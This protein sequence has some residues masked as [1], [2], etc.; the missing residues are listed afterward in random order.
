V[1]A[2]ARPANLFSGATPDPVAN[3]TKLNNYLTA[4]RLAA[5]TGTGGYLTP[6]PDG[7]AFAFP[8]GGEWAD[9]DV[10]LKAV[11]SNV[12]GVDV[13]LSAL[14]AWNKNLA[15]DAGAELS[16][17]AAPFSLNGGTLSGT[18][19]FSGA[20]LTIA[21]GATLAPGFG[22]GT[23]NGDDLTLNGGGT[24]Q[25]ELSTIDNTSDLLNLSGVFDK[26]S[27]GA[28]LFDFESGGLDGQTYTLVG[29]T[30]TS[31]AASDFS[32]TDLGAGLAGTFVVNPTDLQLVVT[33][34]PE[35]ASIVS[36]LGGLVSL[37]GFRRLRRAA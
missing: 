16:T 32:Y 11:N 19:T 36:L 33:V 27:A 35:P 2:L 37:L 31:F 14:T 1:N 10:G 17:G 23:L 30:G 7:V 20:G 4:V 13:S 12:S 24:M 18:G 9:T 5:L 15:I 26:G 34:V 28:F 29:F 3:D 21:A 6:A 22:I 25:F 8:A